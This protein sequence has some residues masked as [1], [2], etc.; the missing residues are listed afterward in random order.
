MKFSVCIP[1]Y[2]YA[3]YVGDTVRSVLEQSHRD[4]EVLVSDN[5]STDDSVAVVRAVADERVRV[6]VNRCNVGFAGNLDRAVRGAS[7]DVALLLSSDDLMLPGALSAYDALFREAG[8]RPVLV[9]GAVQVIDG[10]G[11][12]TGGSGADPAL[13]GDARHDRELAAACGHPVRVLAAPEAL[14]R[15]LRTMRTPGNFAAT[16]YPLRCYE[17]V[18]GYGGG[19]LINPD[20]WFHWRLLGEVEEVWYV[21]TP[22]FAYRW[23]AAN[24]KALQAGQRAL[25]VLVDDYVS[26][27]E[28]SEELLARAGLTRDDVVAAFVE[29]DVARHGLAS[30]A[31]GERTG[32]GRVL[33]FGRAAYPAATRRNR[34]ALAL[35]A[36][37]AL[38][39]FGQ[40]LAASRYHRSAGRGPSLPTP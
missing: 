13:W 40:R 23:H 36:L 37:L 12:P 33:R 11:R 29:Y 25:K 22:L 26:T 18:E 16:A 20:K 2:N 8:E 10:E 38:G 27:F 1:N 9:T 7:G 3:R 14:R 35:R 6:S 19:R 4:V 21:D 17:S 31:R 28:L 15:C 5:A 34:R 30:L 39:P 32:A 24:Q